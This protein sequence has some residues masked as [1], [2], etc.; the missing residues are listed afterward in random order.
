MTVSNA[1]RS[2]PAESGSGTAWPRMLGP[3]L[4]LKLL[5]A[6]CCVFIM[7]RME[8]PQ[9]QGKAMWERMAGYPL[10]VAAVPVAW[11]L[12]RRGGHPVGGYP[13]ASDFLLTLGI[14][15][16]LLGNIFDL[17]DSVFWYDDLMHLLNWG[18]YAGAFGAL[19]LRGSLAPWPLFG[20]VTGFGAVTAILWEGMEWLGFIRFGTEMANA[21]FDTLLDLH[22][23]LLG[24]TVAGVI[25]ARIAAR[26][27]KAAGPAAPG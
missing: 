17:Y 11:L 18:F 4:G 27:A 19:L 5:F 22:L 21:Y 7:L 14:V 16:D 13:F 23:G 8:L 26:R 9:L 1:A 6:A 24:S 15:L 25:V 12:L 3:L 10:L 20:L 2:N